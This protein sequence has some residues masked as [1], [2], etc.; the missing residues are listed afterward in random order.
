MMINHRNDVFARC[1]LRSRMVNPAEVLPFKASNLV[2]N[3]DQ[4]VSLLNFFED[5][6]LIVFSEV[7]LHE[8]ACL[9]HLLRLLVCNW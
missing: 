5:F 8:I 4:P 1:E 6:G 3:V 9:T 7:H 2:S